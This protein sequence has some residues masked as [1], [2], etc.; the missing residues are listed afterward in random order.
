MANHTQFLR[1]YIRPKVKRKVQQVRYLVSDRSDLKAVTPRLQPLGY[2]RIYH[3]HIRKTA[4][5]SLNTAF[6]NAF[7]DPSAGM[8]DEEALFARNWGVIAGKVYVNH[9]EY[10]LERGDFFYGDGHG[11]FHEL[12]IPSNTF[13]IT[14]LRDPAARVLSYYRMLMHWKHNDIKHPARKAEEAYVGSCFGEFLERVPR[15]HLMRQLYMFSKTFDVA[16]AAQNIGTLN[17]VMTTEDFTR[18][19]STLAAL[20]NIDLR[21]YRQKSSYGAVMISD[22]DRA[23]LV[24]VLAPEYAL[25]EAVA[26][27]VG[28]HREWGRPAQ[29][30]APEPS[31]LGE[32]LPA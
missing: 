13:R 6:K 18:H 23:R 10:L 25:L 3:Y 30:E 2:E 21:L 28:V 31:S 17:F 1:E 8:A 5:S 16:E 19:L 26:P 12:A 27:V 9:S 14:I 4:G 29:V 11:A 20:L 22:S 32:A 7:R 15:E 24:E